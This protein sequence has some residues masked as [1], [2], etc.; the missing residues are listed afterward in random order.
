VITG[1]TAN[2]T[3]T[4]VL[5]FQDRTGVYVFNSG[6][7]TQRALAAGTPYSN[8]KKLTV[9]LTQ[10]SL[11]RIAGLGGNIHLVVSHDSGFMI[12][13]GVVS[14]QARVFNKLHVVGPPGISHYMASMR[15]HLFRY[16][17]SSPGF[18]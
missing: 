16:A 9:F 15:F 3:P 4:I 8:Q 17:F 7:N 1:N 2:T 14:D 12:V 11:K 6:E 10:T 18:F 5:H 13:L